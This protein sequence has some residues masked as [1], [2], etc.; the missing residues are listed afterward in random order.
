MSQ[1]HDAHAIPTAPPP[2]KLSLSV[3]AAAL[4]AVL[5]G[6]GAFFFALSGD[7]HGQAW[8]AFLI[9]AFYA[10]S[11]GLFG[12]LWIAMLYL[13]KGVWS[14]SMRRI[15][16]A[17]SAWIL[18]GAV[19][20]LLLGALGGHDLYHW[21]HLEAVEADEL[22]THKQP[23][24]NMGM[25][26]ALVGGSQLIWLVLGFLIVRN[27]RRQDETG[28]VALSRSNVVLSAVFVVLYALTFST[29]SFFLL[30]SLDAHWF[31]TIYAVL[32]FTDMIQTGTA[33]VALV[34]SLLILRGGLD[35]FVN[36]NHLHSLAKMMFAATG[37]WAYI[38]FCQFLL[39]WYGNLPEE[40]AYF[41]TR[42]ESGWLAYLLILPLLKFLIPFIVM[43]PRQAKRVPG[44]VAPMAALILF[45]QFWELLVLVSPAIGHGEHRAQAH[46]PV[47]EF[48]VTLGFFGLFFLVFAWVLGRHNAVP[49]KDP[50]MR[51]CLGYHQ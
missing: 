41:I 25:F 19:L 42:W 44:R 51:E 45:A 1:H 16:E 7:H 50:R 4:V 23:F 47:I 5:I 11:L 13:G 24:L 28:Q 29:V 15:P 2:I 20:V 43:V 10:L 38:Y 21:T 37:F 6:A 17:M 33:F 26:Y 48:L 8:S 18:P 39:I 14:V 32:T 12:V 22:L 27:S 31:S 40:T 9:G 35:G 3:R 34:V 49:L 46:L 36:E 30:M